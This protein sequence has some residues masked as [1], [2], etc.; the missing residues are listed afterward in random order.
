M[1]QNGS[2]VILGKRVRMKT[3]KHG[4]AC[5]MPIGTGLFL[6]FSE[7][8]V[9]IVAFIEIVIHVYLLPVNSVRT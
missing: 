2:C 5:G 1:L 3:E 8:I 6:L 7:S 4:A 9:F